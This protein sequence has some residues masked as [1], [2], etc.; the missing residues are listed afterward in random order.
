MKRSDSFRSRNRTAILAAGWGTLFLCTVWSS[1]ALEIGVAGTTTYNTTTKKSD[2]G[3]IVIVRQELW[4][5]L[6]I[7]GRLGY[8]RCDPLD[9]EYIPLEASLAFKYPLCDDRF[10]PFAGMFGGMHLFLDG[11][12]GDLYKN[13]ESIAPYGGFDWRFGERKEWSL[14]V[15]VFYQLADHAHLKVGNTEVPRGDG[16][17][18]SI[19]VSFRF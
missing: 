17:G 5:Y 4:R 10:V 1:H 15:E 7:G 11:S 18:C 8:V 13:A 19:G 3:G 16:P 6:D 2:Y 14:Y 12:Q 9:T